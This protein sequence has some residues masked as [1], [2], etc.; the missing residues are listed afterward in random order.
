MA[1]GMRD[2]TPYYLIVIH[3]DNTLQSK[4][5][6]VCKSELRSP[7][8]HFIVISVIFICSWLGQTCYTGKRAQRQAEGN[9]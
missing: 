6:Q 9:R 3:L 5:A 1:A 2:Q 4:A 7:P 8:P